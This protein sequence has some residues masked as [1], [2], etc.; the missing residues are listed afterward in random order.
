MIIL[1]FA[2]GRSEQ[3]IDQFKYT[4]EFYKRAKEREPE[5]GMLLNVN[6]KARGIDPIDSIYDVLS[7]DIKVNDSI[8]TIPGIKSYMDDSQIE[9]L[10]FFKNME[11]L[12][13]YMDLPPSASYDS[14]KHLSIRI[15]DI[16]SNLKAFGVHG[17]PN[18]NGEFIIFNVTSDYDVIYVPDK[19]KVYY[20]YWKE[21]FASD[22]T[23]DENWY[24][25]KNN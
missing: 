25:R 20:K 7:I 13:Q 2:C 8:I 1:T 18:N 10:P 17:S 16:M 5:L 6:I 12:G 24:Y 21:Y 9:Q 19:G 3:E 11:K 14:I 4:Y 23:F 15:I 22:N